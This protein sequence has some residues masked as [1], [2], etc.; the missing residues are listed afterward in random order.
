[1]FI[2]IEGGEGAGKSRLQHAL[3]AR[4]SA[5][6]RDVLLT[7]EPGGTGLGE[8]VR[9][10]LLEAGGADPLAELLLFEAARAELVAL[11]IQPALAAG[12]DV[13]CDRF[14]GSSVAYQGFGRGLGRDIVEQANAFATGGLAP[15][16]TLL[17]DVPV[18]AGLG[19]REEAGDANHFDL[20]AIA[21]HERVRQGYLELAREAPDAWH[22]IDATQP[23]ERVA[24]EA[25]SAVE[26]ALVQ[27]RG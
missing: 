14:A 10:L 22:I 1:L 20:E 27:A 8:R 16:L 23:F 24:E 13:L 25:W 21:F 18:E 5:A 3:G 12:R 2:A 26:R 11:V 7:R 19:R 6:G 4:L 15:H 17:L 9:S